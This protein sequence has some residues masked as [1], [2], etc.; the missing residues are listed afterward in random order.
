ME[1]LPFARMV[2]EIAPMLRGPAFDQVWMNI[3]NSLGLDRIPEPARAL[4]LGTHKVEQ[5][6]V[7]GYWDE[8]LTT[9]P[10]EL[11]ARID[12]KTAGIRVPCLAVFGRLATHGE[13]ERLDDMPDVEIEEWVG[14]GHFVHLVD[15]RRFATRI[16]TFVDYCDQA[17]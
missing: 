11:Q 1:M 12:A 10:A 6:V 4:A 3:E 8:V 14:D 16:G 15:P 2:H 13:R 5:D 17:T 7:L 9:D